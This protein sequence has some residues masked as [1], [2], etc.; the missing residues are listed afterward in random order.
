MYNDYLRDY[1]NLDLKVYT[2]ESFLNF[3]ESSESRCYLTTDSGRFE[4]RKQ[5]ISSKYNDFKDY[6]VILLNADTMRGFKAF[7]KDWT[8][9]GKRYEVGETFK[10]D[11]NMPIPCQSGMHFCSNLVDVFFYYPYDFSSSKV[12]EVEAVGAITT[13]DGEKFCTNKMKIIR[14]VYP[15]EILDSIRQSI[16]RKL[17]TKLPGSVV[18]DAV[19]KLNVMDRRILKFNGS[20]RYREECDKING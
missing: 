17:V 20:Y 2:P 3:I 11:I 4:C 12:A 18:A 9:R 5:E 16:Y 14:E 7:N 10:E 13:G 8:C 19:E 1:S 15:E 6:P